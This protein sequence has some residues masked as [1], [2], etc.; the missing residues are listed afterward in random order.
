MWRNSQFV[1]GM[2]PFKLGSLKYISSSCHRLLKTPSLKEQRGFSLFE[3]LIHQFTTV[4]DYLNKSISVPAK[5]AA[6]I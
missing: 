5:I 6:I 2:R 1:K 4:N 3:G